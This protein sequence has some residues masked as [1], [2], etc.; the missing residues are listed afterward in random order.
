M[1][2]DLRRFAYPLEPLR[3]RREWDLDAA[4]AE[5]GRVQAELDA[6]CREAEALAARQAQATRRVADGLAAGVDP[7]N[8]RRALLWLAALRSQTKAAEA[9]VASLRARR[10]NVSARCLEAQRRLDVVVRHREECLADYGK[11][12]QARDAAD[13][14]REWL[15]RPDAAGP[16]PEGRDRS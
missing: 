10:A 6:A 7:A 11:D 2:V 3:R 4:R 1:T 15:A 14:D 5:L 16:G 13:A 8:H 12:A 9:R